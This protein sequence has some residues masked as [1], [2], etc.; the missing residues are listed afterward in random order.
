MIELNNEELERWSRVTL[1]GHIEV[2]PS[3]Q[4]LLVIRDSEGITHYWHKEHTSILEGKEV[5][6]KNGQYDGWSAELSNKKAKNIKI[7]E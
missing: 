1:H 3:E 5:K 4:Y 2:I 7:N 6:F